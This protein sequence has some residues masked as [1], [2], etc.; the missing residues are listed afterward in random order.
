MNRNVQ[1]VAS[2]HEVASFSA[3]MSVS[4]AESFEATRDSKTP[5]IRR[6]AR[7]HRDRKSDKSP[8]GLSHTLAK[9]FTP[10]YIR[11]IF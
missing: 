10:M 2:S 7:L 6:R 9:T 11:A 8:G 5:K 1:T 4:E 3:R